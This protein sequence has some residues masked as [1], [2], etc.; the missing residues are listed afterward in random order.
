MGLT[1]RCHKSV[2]HYIKMGVMPTSLPFVLSKEVMPIEKPENGKVQK[3]A[4]M[5]CPDKNG[6]SMRTIRQILKERR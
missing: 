3:V 2:D 4:T 5:P 1:V 6:G